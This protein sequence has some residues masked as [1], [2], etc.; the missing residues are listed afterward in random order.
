M[1]QIHVVCVMSIKNESAHVLALY[2]EKNPTYPTVNM[3]YI[4]ISR[5]FNYYAIGPWDLS[6]LAYFSQ[7]MFSIIC[8][9]LITL[10]CLKFEIVADIDKIDIEIFLPS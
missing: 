7:T 5:S 8:C 1:P 3:A 9:A 4:N 2:L 6:P 10:V